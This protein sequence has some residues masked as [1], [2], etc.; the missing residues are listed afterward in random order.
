MTT[1]PIIIGLTGN[2]GTGK[3]T[4]RQILEG[5]GFMGMAFADPIRAMLRELLLGNGIGDHYINS[6]EFKEAI[7]PELGVSYREMAQTLGTE[8]GRSLQADFWLR[9]ASAYVADLE[10][11]G[12]TQIVVSDV[13]FRNEADWVRERGGVIWRVVR[14][15]AGQ[16]RSHISEVG[17]TSIVHDHIIDNSGDVDQLRITVER[18]LGTMA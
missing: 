5:Q 8:W 4:V 6:R 14:P 13:R 7:I 3:D 17:M 2:A 18:A 11:E 1:K 10:H 12:C 9:L 16:V 15:T